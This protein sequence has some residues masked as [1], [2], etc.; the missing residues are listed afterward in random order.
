MT[1][2]TYRINTILDLLQVPADR[3]EVCM[4]ELLY[5]LTTHELLLGDIPADQIKHEGFDWTDDGDPSLH[6]ELGDQTFT[7]RMLSPEGE[8]S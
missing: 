5:G 3:R 6:V 2:P 8:G 7:L 4:R 1:H